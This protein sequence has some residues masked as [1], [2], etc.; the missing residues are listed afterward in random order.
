MYGFATWDANG[1]D[2]NTG[3]VK[4][5]AIAS[6]SAD[7]NTSGSFS[8]GLPSGYTMDFLIQPAGKFTGR[9]RIQI[10]GNVITLTNVADND[11][12]SD[13]YPRYDYSFILIYAR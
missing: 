8:Y 4:I 9:R 13:T 2:N 3:I 10:S 6:L 7:V 12:S 5:N 1:V 11:Y